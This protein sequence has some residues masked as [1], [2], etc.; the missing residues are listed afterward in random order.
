MF[1]CF[2]YDYANSLQLLL[3]SVGV[4]ATVHERKNERKDRQYLVRVLPSSLL[5]FKTRVG[6]RDAYT[7]QMIEDSSVEENS[8]LPKELIRDIGR[9]IRHSLEYKKQCPAISRSGEDIFWGRPVL[10]A[11]DGYRRLRTKR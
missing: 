11:A 10:L 9:Y 8:C 4:G 7:L 1:K 2:T 6:S 5:L 3:T